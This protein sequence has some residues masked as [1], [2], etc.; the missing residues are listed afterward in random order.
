MERFA[1]DSR[2]SRLLELAETRFEPKIIDKAMS[3]EDRRSIKG[4]FAVSIVVSP[5]R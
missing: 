5:D 4:I 2:W 1:I 3:Q